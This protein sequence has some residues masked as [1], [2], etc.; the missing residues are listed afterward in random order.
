MAGILSDA[1]SGIAQSIGEQGQATQEISRSVTEASVGT[2]TVARAIGEVGN[3]VKDASSLADSLR[4]DGEMLTSEMSVLSG[5]VG[6]FLAR[7]RAA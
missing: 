3:S 6:H 4:Q 7:L 1:S 5:R 2:K